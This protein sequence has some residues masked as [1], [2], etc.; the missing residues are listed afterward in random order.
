MSNVDGKITLFVMLG[1][2]ADRVIR[3]HPEVA[4][5]DALLLS[6][7]FDLSLTLPNDAKRSIR[8]ALVYR[9]FFVFENF[10]RR[11]VFQSLSEAEPEK[12]WNK[13]PTDVQREV[14]EL[15]KR[16]DSKQWM[17]LEARDKI[18][19]TTFPQLLRIVEHRWKEEFEEIVLDKSLIQAGRHI[20]HLRNAIC[21]M[22]DIPDEEIER[23]RQT[24]RDWFR[25]MSP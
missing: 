18:S 1:Q 8:A 3:E 23:V 20:G 19:L 2:T 17:S 7:T 6:D 24:M 12:W 15:E 21:P 11:F 13:V 25:V 14:E 22:T 9:L 5:T 10:L 4:P 16:E